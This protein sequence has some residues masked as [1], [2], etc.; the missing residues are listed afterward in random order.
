MQKKPLIILIV[1][2][3]ISIFIVFNNNFTPIKFVTGIV[4][5]IFEG[6][7]A[8]LT[9]MKTGDSMDSAQ[10]KKLKDEN[11]ALT[12][13]FVDYENMK[14]DNEALRSQFEDGDTKDYKLLPARVIGFL[15][16][17]SFP[18]SLIINKGEKDSIKKGMAV[19]IDNKL[20]G[21]ISKVSV[22]Y[23]EIT[24]IT[25]PDFT[26]LARSSEN[27][28]PGIVNGA[29]DFV[30]FNR[31]DVNEKLTVGEFVLTKGEVNSEGFGAPPDL[32]IGKIASVNK[33]ESLPF[34]TAK[35][36]S[37]IQFSKLSTVFVILG[38]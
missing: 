11:K 1:L 21:K 2:L 13:K 14:R 28:A 5:R 26:G 36:E 20:I 3:L 31:V 22:D 16:K 34:Q 27:S 35:V 32:I 23:S 8:I 24:L 30:L 6:P 38:L 10:I 37:D 9:G 7:K 15:G 33:T 12:K 18:Q 19:I 25:S 29:H 4:E 17:F